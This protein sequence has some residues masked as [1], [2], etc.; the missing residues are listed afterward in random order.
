[1]HVLAIPHEANRQCANLLQVLYNSHP[2]PIC[3]MSGSVF[4]ACK[5]GEAVSLVGGSCNWDHPLTCIAVF[6]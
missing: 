2:D 6:N 3:L 4:R 5:S 1:M